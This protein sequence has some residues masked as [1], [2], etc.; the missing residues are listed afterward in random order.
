MWTNM[1]LSKNGALSTVKLSI[2]RE[3]SAIGALALN[4]SCTIVSDL[5]ILSDS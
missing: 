4:H 5:N 2:S 3:L 1:K